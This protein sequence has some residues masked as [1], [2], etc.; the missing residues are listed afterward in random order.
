MRWK[1]FL[2]WLAAVVLIGNSFAMRAYG[3]VIRSTHLFIASPAV[4]YPLATLNLIVG[5]VILLALVWGLW[6]RRKRS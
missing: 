3:D 4:F 1:T 2:L 6:S 5:L